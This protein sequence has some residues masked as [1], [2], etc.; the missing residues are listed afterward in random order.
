M[1]LQEGANIINRFGQR[2]GRLT[3]IE[4]AGSIGTSAA[5]LCECICGNK[6]IVASNGLRNGTK[7][8]GC[9]R[10]TGPG[11]RSI[12]RSKYEPGSSAKNTTFRRYKNAADDRNLS[13]ELSKAEFFAIIAMDCAY[14]GQV[15]NRVVKVSRNGSF[16]RNGV[17]RKDNKI[18]YTLANVVPC[19]SYC[20]HA[21]KDHSYDDF[22][23]WLDQI[24]FYRMQN[25]KLNGPLP[26]QS[27]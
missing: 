27:A 8:C 16:T 1:R 5:W 22:I 26:R 9:S 4:R 24:A 23:S 18:G 2:Y 10:K 3:V 11:S 12:Y 17:D 6:K 14:C 19:C 21:K 25:R 7:S 20:N 13:W 15:P